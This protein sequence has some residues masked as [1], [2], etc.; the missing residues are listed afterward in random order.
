MALPGI[1]EYLPTENG[2]YVY[3]QDNTFSDTV[4]IG[5]LQYDINTYAIRYVPKN[6]VNN[7]PILEI[8][9]TLDPDKDYV[10]LTGE[11][12]VQEVT[13]E[14]TNILN[15]MHDLLYEFVARR[16]KINNADFSHSYIN[17]I[18][19]TEEYSQFGG[20]VT[21]K[22]NA[23]IPLF[24]LETIEDE[25][26][27]LLFEIVEIGKITDES[28]KGWDSFLCLP[29]NITTVPKIDVTSTSISDADFAT[30][31][32][33]WKQKDAFYFIGEEA[34][35]YSIE[36]SATDR[37][38]LLRNFSLSSVDNTI[39]LQKQQVELLA[40]NILRITNVTKQNNADA[41]LRDI[42]I[43]KPIKNS[44]SRLTGITVYNNYYEINTSYFNRLIQTSSSNKN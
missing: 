15:Y 4:Y 22:Y 33:N 17:P 26:G 12:V 25:E 2:Q 6:P 34:L 16:K 41:F 7:I 9:V 11:K 3:Y 44:I 13:N 21:L 29:K 30:F 20:I 39:Y 37:I 40:D 38:S 42:K 8:I 19:S 32:D 18:L 36:I 28:E 31:N 27:N 35:M 23:V 10:D 14:N 24:S 5:F 1:K 43:I